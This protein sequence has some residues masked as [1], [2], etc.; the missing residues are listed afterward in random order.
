M[1]A[2]SDKVSAV[3]GS[4]M[5]CPSAAALSTHLRKVGICGTTLLT[6]RCEVADDEAIAEDQIRSIEAS[7]GIR[8]AMMEASEQRSSG[9][10]DRG[11]RR[12]SRSGG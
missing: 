9:W 1:H 12:I 10:M 7:R 8:C 11:G 6:R 4:R 3:M 5:P 2:Q